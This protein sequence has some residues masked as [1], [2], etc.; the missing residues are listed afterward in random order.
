MRVAPDPVLEPNTLY[1]RL[2]SS[3]FLRVWTN[4]RGIVGNIRGIVGWFASGVPEISRCPSW[5][6]RLFDG[7]YRTFGVLDVLHAA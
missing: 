5:Q 4:I 6:G 2:V 3:D 7:G 1:A